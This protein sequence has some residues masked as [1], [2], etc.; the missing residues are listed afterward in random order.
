MRTSTACAPLA[1]GV[2]F[3]F[4]PSRSRDLE[5]RACIRRWQPELRT[6]FVMR[7]AALPGF[8]LT[9][10]V[11]LRQ[12]AYDEGSARLLEAMADRIEGRAAPVT[13]LRRAL[14]DLEVEA[15]R[16][17]PAGRAQPLVTLL[18]KI[19]EVTQC[20][21]AQIAEKFPP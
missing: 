21:A 17:L 3:E 4:G 14:Y 20:L 11:R 8:E 16:E 19:D 12:Q 15:S 6:L 13:D 2:L 1:D 18:R 9:E 5:L 7:I 10:T